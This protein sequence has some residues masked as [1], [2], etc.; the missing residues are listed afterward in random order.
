[1]RP[2]HAATVLRR[3][4]RRLALRLAPGR[5]VTTPRL[6]QLA[7]AL[8]AAIALALWGF[9]LSDVDVSDLGSYGL[10]PALGLGW[11]CALLIALVGVVVAITARRSSPLIM[12]VYLAVVAAILYGSVPVLS[13]QPHYAWVYKHIGVVRYLEAHGKVD[14][15]IDIYNRWPGF[16]A[17][18]AVFS[19]VAG[20]ND[21]ETYAGWAELFFMLLDAVLLM[22]AVRAITRS[23]RIAAGAALFFLVTNWVG[24][25]YF[26]PQAFAFALALALLLI[27]L[28]QLT[29]AGTS[30]S[31]LLTRAIERVGRVPQLAVQPDSAARWPRWAA[32]AAVLALNAVIVA[33][34]QLTPYMLLS[35]G[36]LLMLAGVVRPW[37]MLALMAVMAFAY[38]GANFTFVEHNYGVF[39]SIDPFN[40]VQVSQYTQTPVAGKVFNTHAQLLATL[41]FLLGALFA[42]VRLWRAGLLMRALPFALL[43]VAPF[44]VIFGQNYGGEASLRIILFASPWCAALMSWALGTVMR[45]R[46]RFAITLLAAGMFSALFVPAFLG[47][48]ELNIISPA[49]VR[50]SEWFYYHARPGSVLL[51]SAPGFPYRYGGTYPEFKGPEGDANPNLLS[52]PAFQSRQLGAAQVPAVIARVHEYAPRGYIAFAKDQTAFGEVMGVTPP[53]ALAHLEAAIASSPDFRLW[54]ANRDVQIYE[55]IESR[56]RLGAETHNA[57]AL[58]RPELVQPTSFASSLLGFRRRSPEPRRARERHHR[59][60]GAAHGRSPKVRAGARRG[61]LHRESVRRPT[62]RGLLAGAEVS[63]W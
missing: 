49:E 43:A 14:P 29:V 51:L 40:N 24:Q 6:Q 2:E 57:L 44:A 25:A 37:W 13:A 22:A 9:S 36:A 3:R 17:V 34:H 8:P 47:A 21:P 48:E 4:P 62:A 12:V 63:R 39:T 11:Y 46:V 50:A 7:L 59:P 45:R 33:S 26:S 61:G 56:A 60:P 10:P 1:M 15:S 54:Y 16:F 53:G 41:A 32:I 58:S 38:F 42:V 27:L 35:S 5:L 28:R 19:R 52:A 31:R 20:A 30:Y 23:V 55:L 18:A